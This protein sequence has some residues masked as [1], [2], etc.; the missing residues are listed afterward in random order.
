MQAPDDAVVLRPPPPGEQVADVRAAIRD[1]FRFPLAGDALEALV[2]RGGRATI[3]VEPP[4][5]PIPGAL[6]DPRQA[7]LAAT[8]AELERAGVPMERQ[9]LLVAT[10]L[11]RRPH[12]RDL[13]GLGIVSPGFARRFH[14]KVEIHDAEDPGLVD[15]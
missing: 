13:E 1:A 7:A 9:T 10:G 11:T 6:Q 2:T 5:L 14:G 4:A 8:S 3:V 15:L 12:R